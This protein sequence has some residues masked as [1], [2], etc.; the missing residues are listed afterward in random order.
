MRGHKTL[1]NYYRE[2]VDIWKFPDRV[3]TFEQLKE[4]VKND[5]KFESRIKAL[6][7][8]KTKNKS[9]KDKGV[10]KRYSL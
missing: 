10:K 2:R 1:F 4:K 8:Y 3:Y 7:A 5:V 9:A 6:V